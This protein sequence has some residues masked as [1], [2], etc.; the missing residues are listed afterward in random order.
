[1]GNGGQKRRAI[2]GPFIFV[3]APLVSPR[4]ADR[5]LK[6][7]KH[8]LEKTKG[9]PG[10]KAPEKGVRRIWHRISLTLIRR[11]PTVIRKE[12]KRGNWRKG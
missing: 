2:K 3:K 4:E 9:I 1:V 8:C 7:G 5:P 10:E 12:K 11:E 6:K